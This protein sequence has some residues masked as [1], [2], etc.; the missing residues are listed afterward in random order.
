MSV[1]L[2]EAIADAIYEEEGNKPGQ[3][4][5]RNR[6]P[7]N[8]RPFSTDQDRDSGGYRIFPSFVDGYTALLHDIAVK[9]LGMGKS[10]LSLDS[11]LVQFFQVYAPAADQ[12]FPLRYARNVAGYL[13]RV[14]LIVGL[15]ENNTFRELYAF[16]KQE[17]PSGVEPNRDPAAIHE[18]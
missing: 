11:T 10:G 9:I 13:A 8:L 17:V 2:L 12:N 16:A 1:P 15:T 5:N 4:A 18:P 3:R 14:Y 7:G 6:N